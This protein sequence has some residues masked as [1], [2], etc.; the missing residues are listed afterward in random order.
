M[1]RRFIH[2]NSAFYK[3][4]VRRLRTL[5]AVDFRNSIRLPS[6]STSR[7]T[8]LPSANASCYRARSGLSPPSYRPCWA[9]S[10]S[11]LPERL[12]S[13]RVAGNFT[14]F[15]AIMAKKYS[16]PGGRQAI[17]LA[18]TGKLPALCYT[19]FFSCTILKT[20]DHPLPE[21]GYRSAVPCNPTGTIRR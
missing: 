17:L 12:I 6:D 10:K 7:W 19:D 2:S 11:T 8:P 18:A 13:G 21:S 4:S 3:V 5:P 9:H 16:F 20:T 15:Q 14:D 1:C